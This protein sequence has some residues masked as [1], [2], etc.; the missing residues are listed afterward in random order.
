MQI[1]PSNKAPGM[2]GY[3]SHFFKVACPIMQDDFCVAKM[4]FLNTRMILKEI[5]VTLITIVPKIPVHA[6]VGDFTP[7]ACCSTIYK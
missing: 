4:D 1:I 5:N 3:N 7:I 6:S 2:D